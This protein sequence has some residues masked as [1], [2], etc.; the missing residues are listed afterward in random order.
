[1]VWFNEFTNEKSLQVQPNCVRRL[2]IRRSADQ[3]E[4]EIIEGPERVR[5]FMNQLQQRIVRPEYIYVGPEEEGDHVFWY[6]W[7]TMHSKIDYPI[8]YGPRVVHQGWIPSHRV[9]RG[10][11]AVAH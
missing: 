2:L 9:P 7:G 6:N 5:G 1:M 10:P 4:P 3:K 11:T 8:A